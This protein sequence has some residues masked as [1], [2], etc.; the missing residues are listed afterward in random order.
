MELSP[1]EGGLG[2]PCIKDSSSDQYKASRII[3][4]PHVET[5]VAQE[6]IKRLPTLELK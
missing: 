1:G 5:I 6:M 2:I 4:K 3:T